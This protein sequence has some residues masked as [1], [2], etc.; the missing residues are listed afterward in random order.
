LLLAE[1]EEGVRRLLTHVLERAGYQ[2]LE[3]ANG[4]EALAIFEKQG[5]AVDL[6]L[7]D[8]VMPKMSGRELAERVLQIR[9]DAKVIFMSGYTDDVLI[10][11]GA[12]NPGMSFLQKPLRAATLIAKIRAALDERSLP[13]SRG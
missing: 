5:A 12:L 6:V 10:R 9:P 4:E 13:L 7:T 2:V 8:M 1:D 3:A 11:T